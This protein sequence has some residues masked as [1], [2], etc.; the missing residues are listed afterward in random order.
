[1]STERLTVEQAAQETFESIMGYRFKLRKADHLEKAVFYSAKTAIERERASV[2]SEEPEWEYGIRAEGDD[3]PYTDH[4]DDPDWLCDQATPE[5]GDAIVRRR[6][7]GSWLP[8][9]QK[10]TGQ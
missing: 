1:M 4:S 3:E 6:K 9:E 7:S 8:V 2:V 5:P 10:G